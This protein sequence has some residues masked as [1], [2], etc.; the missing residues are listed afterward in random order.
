MNQRQFRRSTCSILR[1]RKVQ[2]NLKP[3]KNDTKSE[4]K[5]SQL[6]G[7]K[8]VPQVSQM[9]SKMHQQINGF[10]KNR[11]VQG[12]PRRR[13]GYHFGA[14]LSILVPILA[15]ARFRRHL[16]INQWRIKSIQN[17]PKRYPGWRLEKTRFGCDFLKPKWKA[18]RSKRKHF[19]LYLLQFYR[20]R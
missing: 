15:P 4:V 10:P 5:V 9:P 8:R 1:A 6:I 13:F 20:F 19:A 17:C 16:K 14:T 11:H 2:R 18:S 3:H 7:T 12:G